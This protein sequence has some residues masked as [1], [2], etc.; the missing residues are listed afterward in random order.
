MS[1]ASVKVFTAGD[2]FAGDEKPA[3]SQELLETLLNRAG[4]TKGYEWECRVDKLKHCSS[5][6]RPVRVVGYKNYG[7]MLRVK[8]NVHSTIDYQMTLYIPQG[9][10]YSAKNLFEQ[11]KANEKSVSRFI[12]QQNH[13]EKREEKL[14]EEPMENVIIPLAPFP[15]PVVEEPVVEN[16]R[17]EC[18]PE[19]KTLQAVLKN[20]DKLR[21]VLQKI[22]VVNAFDFC[23]NKL[24]F[25]ETLKHE[26]KWDKE[27]H[28]KSAVG[29]VLTELVKFD[30]LM[31]TV[32]DRDKLIGYSLTQK[33]LS[34]IVEALPTPP[35]AA[36]KEE[37]KIDISV[38]LINMRDKLRELSDV[39]NKIAANNAERAEL[40]RKVA[41]IDSENEDLSKIMG[42]NK[43]CKEVL[44]KLSAIIAPLPLQGARCSD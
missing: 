17:E 5:E 16:N 39:A 28:S 1:T 19:F 32:N 42:Q 30:Y 20:G 12:R 27:G 35:V 2:H 23:R 38:I 31:E 36:K 29:R 34:F 44:N 11:L 18:R 6:S 14:K 24:Q 21:Y 25:V 8:P 41:Q 3:E 40:L 4:Y 22:K 13:E 15:K 33:A 10:G 37:E 7:V 9:S 26:C 43:E